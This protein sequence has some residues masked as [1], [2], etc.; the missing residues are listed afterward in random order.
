MAALQM[1]RARLAAIVADRNSRQKHAQRAQVVLLTGDRLG[2]TEIMRRTGLS[3]PSGRKVVEVVRPILLEEAPPIDATHWTVRAMAARAGVSARL[4]D[5]LAS[6]AASERAR[7]REA[8]YA[9]V[10]SI[11]ENSPIQPRQQAAAPSAEEPMPG[12]IGGAPDRTQPD[13]PMKR[14]RLA[15]MTHDYKRHGT[16]TLFTVLNVLD[17]TV[18]GQNRQRH[19]TAGPARQEDLRHPRQIDGQHTIDR[20]R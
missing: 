18:I 15:T 16:T 9:V 17:G 8:E 7:P 1:D 5:L 2:T 14:D 10:L 3:K 4:R 20:A 11:D 19:R 6:S 13:V 12:D